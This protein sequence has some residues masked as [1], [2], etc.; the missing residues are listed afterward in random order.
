MFCR[1]T[2]ATTSSIIHVC[3]RV[4]IQQQHCLL[5][6]VLAAVVCHPATHHQLAPSK[7]DVNTHSNEVE[8]LIVWLFS[9][10]AEEKELIRAQ[11]RQRQLSN[12]R[13]NATKHSDLLSRAS[14]TIMVFGGE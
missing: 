3:F 14:R 10:E 2:A 4:R 5:L 11:F 7:Q 13:K 8:S 1:G 9:A 12:T 6:R